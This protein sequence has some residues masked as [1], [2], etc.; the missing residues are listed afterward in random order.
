MTATEQLARLG[1]Q[2]PAPLAPIGSYVAAVRN[3]DGI[4]T[5]GQLPVGADGLITGQVG[6]DIDVAQAS[7]AARLAVLNA[8]AAASEVAGGLDAIAG[9]IKIVVFVNSAPDFVD[10][11]VVANGASDL[12][13]E[14]FGESG[15]HA[16]SAVGVAAL[17]KGAVVEVELT[18]A[19]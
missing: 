13:V 9:V 10:Q 7:K 16:R 4:V 6:K 11:P 12:L 5:S 2:L 18:V 15:R 1:L 8:L 3:G 17:P 19:L 14:I